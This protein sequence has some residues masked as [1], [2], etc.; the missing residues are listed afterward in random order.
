M[1]KKTE[2]YINFCQQRES[3]HWNKKFQVF[4]QSQGETE[5][6]MHWALCR[7]ADV[8]LW[9]TWELQHLATLA[10]EVTASCQ[11]GW[12]ISATGT[13]QQDPQEDLENL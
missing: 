10:S 7:M 6:A 3:N 13:L 5:I 4:L 1:L 12:N 2:K 9:A 11:T 8:L